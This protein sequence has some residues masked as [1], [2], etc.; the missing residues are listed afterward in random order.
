MNIHADFYSGTVDGDFGPITKTG[1]K[2]WQSITGHPT[3][4]R[5]VVGS[6][7][8]RQLQREASVERLASYISSSAISAAR[9]SGWAVDASKA[10]AQV[11]VLRYDRLLHH[12]VVALSIS[13]AYGG[14]IDGVQYTTYDGVFRIYAE[15][16]ADFV[17]H[18][19][20]NA[21]MP[22]AACFNGG[23]CLHYDGLFPSHGCIHIPSWSAAKFIDRLPLGTTVVVHE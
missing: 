2:R 14:L 9:T 7:Q 17:S 8:W 23:Q 16:G 5:V 20:N 10:P 4:G 1:L 22:Y 19:Y 12:L 11:T 18:K 21:P 15:Y 6:R 3:S 13:A